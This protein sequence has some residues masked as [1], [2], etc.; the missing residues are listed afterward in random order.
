M[1]SLHLKNLELAT[2]CFGLP[3]NF[4]SIE[5]LREEIAA[6][7]RHPTLSLPL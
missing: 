7:V 5:L 1:N 6:Q 3:L 2:L 4:S